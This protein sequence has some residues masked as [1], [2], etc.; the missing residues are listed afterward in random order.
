MNVLCTGFSLF[1]LFS[2]YLSWHYTKH[3]SNSLIVGLFL[4]VL[5]GVSLKKPKSKDFLG[6]I[7]ILVSIVLL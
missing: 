3:L 1:T 4:A 2:S 7:L 6:G 5:I